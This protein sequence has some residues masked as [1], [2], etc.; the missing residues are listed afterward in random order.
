VLRHGAIPSLHLNYKR[1]R[2]K[3]YFKEGRALRTETVINDT[4]DFGIGTGRSLTDENLHALREI[5]FQANR[6]LLDAQ[7]TSHDCLSGAAV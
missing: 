1:S 4:R 2:L 6:R 3:Q 7:K 5:G